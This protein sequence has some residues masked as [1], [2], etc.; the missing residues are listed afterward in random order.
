MKRLAATVLIG[1]I[2]TTASAS[3]GLTPIGELERGSAV[4]VAGTVTRITDEDEFRLTDASG[5]VRVY[6]GPHWVPANL[7]EAVIVAG[8]VD[9][10]LGALELGA[11][12]LVRADGTVFN[13]DRGDD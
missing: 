9:D 5:T 10:D 13:F 6:I 8:T 12:S 1:S 11:I 3:E 7:G 2:A 4:T